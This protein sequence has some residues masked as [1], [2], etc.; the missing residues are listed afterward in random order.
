MEF[1][2]PA[3]ERLGWQYSMELRHEVSRVLQSLYA[4]QHGM[5]GRSALFKCLREAAMIPV[6]LEDGTQ[7]LNFKYP[8]VFKDPTHPGSFFQARLVK[9]Y[10][11]LRHKA[12]SS[13]TESKRKHTPG[14]NA[15]GR[16]N[17]EST[18]EDDSDDDNV[19]KG[20][21]SHTKANRSSKG[22]APFV[23]PA[24]T[25][26]KSDILKLAVPKSIWKAAAKQ[27]FE[28]TKKDN[29]GICLGGACVAGCGRKI[30]VC[31]A[32]HEAMGHVNVR[33]GQLNSNQWTKIANDDEFLELRIAI[34]RNGG[35]RGFKAVECKPIKADIEKVIN[36]LLSAL[37]ARKSN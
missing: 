14:S 4:T 2:V 3:W 28:L 32:A 23:E 36:P 37:A 6:L 13:L 21:A 17:N 34:L 10:H 7:Q 9:Q 5:H 8:L 25:E 30:D 1:L 24:V 19:K 31:Q 15:V 33:H 22:A 20:A 16:A 18:D 11:A 26:F 29:A 35:P 27:L 12:V